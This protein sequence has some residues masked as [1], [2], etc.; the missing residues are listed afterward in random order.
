MRHRQVLTL[1]WGHTASQEPSVDS[2]PGQITNLTSR[3][4]HRNEKCSVETRWTRAAR[5]GLQ[6]LF[7]AIRVAGRWPWANSL[8]SLKS[9]NYPQAYFPYFPRPEKRTVVLFLG[10]PACHLELAELE[11]SEE[12][13]PPPPCRLNAVPGEIPAV[14]SGQRS[15]NLCLGN[16]RANRYPL[17][18]FLPTPDSTL[19]W[20]AL[21]PA[22]ASSNLLWGAARRANGAGHRER[23][24]SRRWAASRASAVLLHDR[25]A[26][27]G[28]AGLADLRGFQKGTGRQLWF[29]LVL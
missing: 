23:T 28:A 21:N 29:G 19:N 20:I 11:R 27:H 14:T 4:R 2:S 7:P 22:G 16:K 18:V 10:P 25:H 3:R 1:A 12:C 24:R 17:T 26:A 8:T 15:D 13:C 6:S 5:P 9:D